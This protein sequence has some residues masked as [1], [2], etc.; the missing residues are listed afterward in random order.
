MDNIFIKNHRKTIS[1]SYP[2]PS[3]NRVTNAFLSYNV[4]KYSVSA[5]YRSK[6]LL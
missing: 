4:W 2:Y 6:K 5:F 3:W 1:S